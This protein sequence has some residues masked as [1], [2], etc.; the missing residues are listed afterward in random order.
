MPPKSKMNDCIETIKEL[1]DMTENGAKFPIGRNKVILDSDE[2]MHLLNQLESSIPQ[3]IK[4][5]RNIINTQ[6]RIR[7]EAEQEAN[8]IIR[9]AERKAKHLLD[10]SEIVRQANKKAEEI[11]T[12]ASGRSREIFNSVKKYC[13]SIFR[14]TDDELS[15]MLDKVRKSDQSLK[16]L[17]Y[18]DFENYRKQNT[19]E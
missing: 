6:E 14:N 17:S 11:I 7:H 8:H 13:D 2:L 9:E 4:E 16:S 12:N 18:T 1:Q 5:A 10:D 19:D 3:E 15:K